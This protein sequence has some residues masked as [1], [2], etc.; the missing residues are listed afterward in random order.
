MTVEFI[1]AI[2]VNPSN[3]INR[4]GLTGVDLPYLKKYARTLEDGGFEPPISASPFIW[5]AISRAGSAIG[6]S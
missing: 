4:L 3:E 2:N 1:S 5:L 6:R